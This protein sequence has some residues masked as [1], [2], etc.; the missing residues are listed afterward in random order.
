[1]ACDLAFDLA[2]CRLCSYCASGVSSLQYRW[3]MRDL[4]SV[5]RTATPWLIVMLHV[6]WYGG[7][8]ARCL[9]PCLSRHPALRARALALHALARHALAPLSSL[10]HLPSLLFPPSPSSSPA[11]SQVPLERGPST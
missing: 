6:P 11:R 1:M 10:T 5:N 9:P 4:A 2:L 3:L 8:A 7:M